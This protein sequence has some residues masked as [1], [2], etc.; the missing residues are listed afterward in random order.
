M[1]TAPLFLTTEGWRDAFPEEVN[2][3]RG[4]MF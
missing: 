2:E 4:Q 1:N 3:I